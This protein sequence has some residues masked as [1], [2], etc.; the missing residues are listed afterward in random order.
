MAGVE[1]THI[2]SDQRYSQWPRNSPNAAFETWFCFWNDLWWADATWMIQ[3]SSSM[4][5]SR[6]QTQPRYLQWR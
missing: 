1:S 3:M 6:D 4:R 5:R 2:D